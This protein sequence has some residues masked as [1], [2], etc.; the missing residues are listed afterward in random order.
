M[1]PPRRDEVSE[2]ARDT[3]VCYDRVMKRTA[4]FGAIGGVLGAVVGL[5]LGRFGAT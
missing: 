5:L 2:A 4:I 3:E 1:R